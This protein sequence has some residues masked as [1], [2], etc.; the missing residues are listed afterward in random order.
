MRVWYKRRA[1]L[2]AAFVF[3]WNL[4][5]TVYGIPG[6]TTYADTWRSWVKVMGISSMYVPMLWA[7]AAASL[8]F[9]TSEFWWPLVRRLAGRTRTDG[10]SSRQIAVTEALT[11]NKMLSD[12]A[13]LISRHREALRPIRSISLMGVWDVTWRLG[14]VSDREELTAHLNAL[15]IRYPPC[16]AERGVW[17]NY[18]V[19]LEFACQSAGLE[20]A[21]SIC[22]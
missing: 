14:Y 12:S 3:V 2:F 15:G 13:P 4:L 5:D 1:G 9:A 6:Y 17:F 18:M 22:D 16:E 8:I 11:E 19:Q 21:R 10:S 7:G 20:R